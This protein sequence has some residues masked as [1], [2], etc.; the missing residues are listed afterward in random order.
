[1]T[2]PSPFDKLPGTEKIAATPPLGQETGKA[3][4]QTFKSLMDS[5]GSSTQIPGAPGS[6]VPAATN[7]PF[8]LAAGAGGR[9]LAT[10][11]TLQSLLTQAAQAQTTL[12]DISN[13]LSTPNLKLKQSQKYLLKNKLTSANTHLRSANAKLGVPPPSEEKAEAAGSPSTTSPGHKFVAL[14]TDGQNQLEAAQAQLK[15]LSASPD[16]VNPAELMLVQLKL[17]KAQQELEYSS[18]MLSNVVSDIKMLFGI[19]L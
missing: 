3:P 13:S 15:K 2:T 18:I 4:D 17:N 5:K 14:V 1:M 9:P 11:P 10:G 8:D 6:K 7:S 19:Q 16:G 12:G